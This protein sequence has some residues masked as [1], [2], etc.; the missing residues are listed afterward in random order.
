MSFARL[1]AFAFVNGVLWGMLVP[2]PKGTLASILVTLLWAI[3]FDWSD[4]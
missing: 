2:G 1:C 3:T 4:E